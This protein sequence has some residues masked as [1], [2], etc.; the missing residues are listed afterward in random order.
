[1]LTKSRFDFMDEAASLSP[2][3]FPSPMFP[4][5]TR[6]F[7]FSLPIRRPLLQVGAFIVRDFARR[8]TPVSVFR[9]PFFQ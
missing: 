5:E 4:I 7:A 9:W 6:D 8:D 1:M 2:R 3:H